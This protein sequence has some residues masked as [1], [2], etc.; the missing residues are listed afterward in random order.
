MATKVYGY[1][2]YIGT[3]TV[4]SGGTTSSTGGLKQVDGVN[5]DGTDGIID[6]RDYAWGGIATPSTFDGTVITFT[7]STSRGGTYYACYDE[8]GT[9]LSIT[10]S[11]SRFQNFPSKLFSQGPF[12]KIVCGTSQSTSDTVFPFVVGA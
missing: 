6:I 9:Q 3:L 5:A 10:T 1:H 7:A 11:S 12:I 8:T 4:V 2:R